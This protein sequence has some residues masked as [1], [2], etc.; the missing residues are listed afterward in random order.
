VQVRDLRP[1][2]SGFLGVAGPVA[3]PL[4][5]G[6]DVPVAATSEQIAATVLTLVRS[7]F[8]CSLNQQHKAN[9]GA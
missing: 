4:L 3:G 5:G 9:R 7:T 8:Y 6:V 1:P 2:N